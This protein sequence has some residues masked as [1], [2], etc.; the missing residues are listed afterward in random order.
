MRKRTGREAKLPIQCAS[1][2]S[3]RFGMW[4]TVWVAIFLAFQKLIFYNKKTP[5]IRRFQVFSGA[6]GQIRTADLILTNNHFYF[7]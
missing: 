2:L 4:V 5:E 3:G 7:L 1:N 6:A